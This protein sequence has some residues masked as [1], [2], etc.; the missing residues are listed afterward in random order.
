MFKEVESDVSALTRRIMLIEEEDKKSAKT[1][2]GTVTKVAKTSKA[3]D[4]DMKTIQVVKNTSIWL[5][6]EVTINERD[7][8]FRSTTKMAADVAQKTAQISSE[9]Q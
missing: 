2:C 4:N 1:L 8:N 9:Y 3:A 6:N 5:N 7:K